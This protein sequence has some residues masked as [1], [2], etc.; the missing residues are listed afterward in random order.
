M[1]FFDERNSPPPR[2]LVLRW[3][4][5]WALGGRGVRCF[6]PDPPS[7][8]RH[9]CLGWCVPRRGGVCV[10][11]GRWQVGPGVR[12]VR[13]VNSRVASS[14]RWCW[15]G[16]WGGRLAGGWCVGGERRFGVLVGWPFGSCGGVLVYSLRVVLAFAA[17][18]WSAHRSARQS[19]CRCVLA[20]SERWPNPSRLPRLVNAVGEPLAKAFGPSLPSAMGGQNR[21]FLAF[22]GR[23]TCLPPTIQPQTAPSHGL[24]ADGVLPARG[25][26]AAELPEGDSAPGTDERA[27]Q[28]PRGRG[29]LR[30]LPQSDLSG[31][32]AG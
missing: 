17:S 10:G 14:C 27:P 12:Q 24:V 9:V 15:C 13:Q 5:A 18:P 7:S 20:T 26:R 25:E 1:G 21:G 30:L 16:W 2:P 23:G 22:I 31:D 32:R 28:S 29:L 4:R 19:A 6:A 8:T 11:A 3:L